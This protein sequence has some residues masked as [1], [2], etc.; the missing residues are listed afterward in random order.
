MRK[1]LHAAYAFESGFIPV[2]RVLGIDGKR[3]LAG[4]V[5]KYREPEFSC[6]TFPGGNSGTS[7]MMEFLRILNSSSVIPWNSGG[8]IL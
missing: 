6:F 3:P 8:N 4:M 5:K 2:D 7:E 1:S